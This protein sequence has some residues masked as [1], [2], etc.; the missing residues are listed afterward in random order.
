M[1]KEDF[2]KRLVQLRYNKGVS[3]REMSLT[4]GQ[5]ENYIN[6]I[7]NGLSLPSM[8]VFFYICDYFN[9]TPKEFFD[10]ESNDP[11]LQR[12]IVEACKGLSNE[13]LEHLLA[14]ARDLKKN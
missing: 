7:E 14:I 5:G 12:K 11:I 6:S 9:I 3:A 13:Q 4:M 2:I 1:E 10:T 8:T